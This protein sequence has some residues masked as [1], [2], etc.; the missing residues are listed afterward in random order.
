MVYTPSLVKFPSIWNIKRKTLN[1]KHLYPKYTYGKK[2]DETYDY[3]ILFADVFRIGETV[4]FV[5]PPFLNFKQT[6]ETELLIIDEN[7]FSYDLDF[8]K[9]DRCDIATANIP[10]NVNKIYFYRN[11]NEFFEVI[12]KKRHTKFDDKKV[13]CT[14]QKNETI[15]RIICWITYYNLIYDIDGFIIFDN[16]STDYTVDFLSDT[17]TKKFPNILIEIVNW[18]MPFGVLG[19][20]WDSDWSQYVFLNLC[21]YNFCYES[22]LV[23]NHD[24]D[25]YFVSEYSIDEIIESMISQNIS[26]VIYESKNISTYTDGNSKILN[27]YYYYYP[28]EVD[29]DKM[30]KWITIPKLDRSCIWNL[31]TIFGN[32]VDK[33]EEFYY[34][35]MWILSSK[36]HDQEK[37]CSSKKYRRNV[38]DNGYLIDNKLKNNFKKCSDLI[39]HG[40]K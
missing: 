4:I 17:L 35:H 6:L 11:N 23:L 7:N 18:N 31:H 38:Y 37:H 12:I 10:E 14:M 13:I 22:K 21:K 33:T 3:D 15:E 2:F 27:D 26:T 16:Q 32:T 34:A 1:E 9:M 40:Q 24:L 36:N 29:R 39:L 8:Y 20:P 19:P 25:E 5:S 28:K 30:T